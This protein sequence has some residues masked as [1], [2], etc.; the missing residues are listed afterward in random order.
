MVIKDTLELGIRILNENNIE[1]SFKEARIILAN[2]LLKTKEYISAY[3]DESLSTEDFDE[4]CRLIEL[5]AKNVPIQ[6]ILGYTEFMKLRFNINENVLIPRHDTEILIEEVL[7]IYKEKYNGKFVEI[8]DLCT[9]SGAI[10]ISLAKY[11]QECTV[12][13]SDISKSAIDVAIENANLNNTYRKMFF[14]YADLF[15]EVADDEINTMGK[16]IYNMKFDFICSNPPYIKTDDINLLSKEVRK[17]PILALD[18]GKDGLD[19]Y[20]KIIKQAKEFL[21]PNGHIV[22]EIG[23]DQKDEVIKLFDKEDAYED[24]YCMKD[25]SQ[26]DRI[27]VARRK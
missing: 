6:Y 18:G 10:G 5:R 7:K 17:E 15:N 22:L 9:G 3:P 21:K 16:R 25:I 1:D 4:F 26:N 19:F 2:V 23:F 12:Y 11:I 20:R 14:K 24:I 8:L 13:V 27:I